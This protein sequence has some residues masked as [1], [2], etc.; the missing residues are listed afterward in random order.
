MSALVCAT[1]RR[2][3]SGIWLSVGDI[4]P[5]HG[6]EVTADGTAVYSDAEDDFSV[7]VQQVDTAV[8][9]DIDA[10]V[11]SVITIESEQAP[12]EYRFPWHFPKEPA[13][14]WTRQPAL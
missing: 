12:T 2:R 3:R 13:L 8:N 6:T 1:G 14:T 10:G 4:Y 11:R 7:A 5:M 9:P